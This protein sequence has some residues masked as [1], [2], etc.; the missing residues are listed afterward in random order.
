[1]DIFQVI[2]E[3]TRRSIIETLA[4][5]GRLSATEIGSGFDMSAPA[6]SQHLKALREAGL[7]RVEKRGKQRM[8][9]LDIG[10]MYEIERWAHG[11]SDQWNRRLDKL[12]ALLTSKK[13]K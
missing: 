7:V 9:E 3:P 1:M 5:R 13:D 12:G 2:A 6:I 10:T 11:M 8:Y 4:K